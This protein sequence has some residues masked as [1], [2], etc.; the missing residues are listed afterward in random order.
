MSASF[1]AFSIWMKGSGRKASSPPPLLSRLRTAKRSKSISRPLGAE[2]QRL[3]SCLSPS[4][5]NPHHG[6]PGTQT[7]RQLRLTFHATSAIPSLQH[8]PNRQ[9]QQRPERRPSLSGLRRVIKVR[10]I[11]AVVQVRATTTLNVLNFEETACDTWKSAAL[12][13]RRPGA[14]I[15]KYGLLKM[16]LGIAPTENRLQ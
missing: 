11:P 6:L 8:S 15:W 12:P 4:G 1:Q 7:L 2:I 9:K 3:V 10:G 14:A 16:S 5:E 13:Q